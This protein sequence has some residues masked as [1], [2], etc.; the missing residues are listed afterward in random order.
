MREAVDPSALGVV[1]KRITKTLDG[2]LLVEITG[3]P[4]AA[5]GAATLSKAVR[6]RVSAL[7]DSVF[8]LGTALEVEIVDL[9]P[10]VERDDRQTAL[11]TAVDALG[12]ENPEAI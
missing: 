3:G 12:C 7:S 11:E 6:E 9:D 2:H 5:A 1:V 4:K 10:G 8:Q